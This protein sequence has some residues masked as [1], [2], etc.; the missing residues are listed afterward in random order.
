MRE[1][2]ALRLNPSSVHTW[3]NKVHNK[4]ILVPLSCRAPKKKG[5]D[6]Q[7]PCTTVQCIELP[8][9]VLS[10]RVKICCV[11]LGRT[12]LLKHLSAKLQRCHRACMKCNISASIN[13]WHLD[14]CNMET[15][16]LGIVFCKVLS[17]STRTEGRDCSGLKEI[18]QQVKI[19][20]TQPASQRCC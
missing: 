14:R 9:E 13:G 19:I 17:P 20:F 16:T 2:W 7:P 1:M 5:L 12:R 10:V 4:N 11:C 18:H 15:L 3:Q 6:F 8:W